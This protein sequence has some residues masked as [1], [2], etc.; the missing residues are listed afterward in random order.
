MSVKGIYN[1]EVTK[2]VSGKYVQRPIIES[3]AGPQ[4]LQWSIILRIVRD[5][6][7]GFVVPLAQEWV[8]IASSCFRAFTVKIARASVTE[9]RRTPAR[10]TIG[11]RH[12]L[13][14]S[15]DING[16]STRLAAYGEAFS[17]YA[18]IRSGGVSIWLKVIFMWM[19]ECIIVVDRNNEDSNSIADL[20]AAVCQLGS[21][22][23]V[24]AD[25]H[26]IEADVPTSEVPTVRAMAGV[27]Y[28][29]CVFNYFCGK[30]PRRAA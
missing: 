30:P 13:R 3:Q 2:A 25:H 22:L 8:F 12:R 16:N 14:G 26:V 5:I 29:R 4:T 10:I 18:A 1:H 6:R 9:P 21:V 20:A 28:V 24:D 11:P 23:N 7:D 15:W 27:S 19:S 17:L